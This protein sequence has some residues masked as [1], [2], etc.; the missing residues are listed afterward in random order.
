MTLVD[1]PEMLH[2]QYPLSSFNKDK[3]SSPLSC[4]IGV[5]LGSEDDTNANGLSTPPE[6]NLD[7]VTRLHR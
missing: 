1:G 2:I 7:K 5:I 4:L 6:Q 3:V